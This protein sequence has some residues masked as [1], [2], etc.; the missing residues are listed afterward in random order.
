MKNT[1]WRIV[2]MA[3]IVSIGG[4][5]LGILANVSGAS[6]FYRSYFNLKTGSFLEGLGVSIAM[7]ATFMG[8]F[9]AGTLS[10]KI[11][12]KKSLLI[13]AFL[14]SFCTLGSGLATNYTFFLL[15]RFIGGFGI[16]ISLVV[17]PM[18]IAEF[19]PS[20]KRGFWVSFNQLNIGIGF[21]VAYVLNSIVISKVSDPD[22][23]WRWMLGIGVVFP[24]IYFFLMLFVPESPRW[25]MM[26]GQEERAKKILARL[27]GEQLLKSE[28]GQMEASSKPSSLQPKTSY[29]STWKELFSKKMRLVVIVAFSVAFFQMASGFN[30]IM[31]F[32]PKIFRLAGFSGNGSFFQSN[33]IG[34]T[35]VVMTIVSMFLID[36]LGRKPLLLIG[37]SLMAVSVLVS[38]IV[39]R[40]STFTIKKADF[41][42]VIGDINEVD[43]RFMNE[44]LV[45]F[46]DKKYTNEIEFFHLFRDAVQAKT[47]ELVDFKISNPLEFVAFNNHIQ[48]GLMQQQSNEKISKELA[49]T[50]YSNSK[51]RLLDASISI[52][53]LLVMI[54]IIGF[55][56][57]FSISL[58]P[59]TWA[60]LSEVFP[61][62]VRG[63]GISIAST[64]NGIAS[65]VIVTILPIELEYLGSSTTFL[66]YGLL[67]V[68]FILMVIKW[69]PETK[70]KSL[71]QI[72]K[73]LVR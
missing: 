4:L 64:L 21:L 27:G 36:R 52:N 45:S 44:V 7:L 63:L 48:E 37:V 14:F 29:K 32:A 55:I 43:A 54:A 61:G 47:L 73:E 68:V 6:E 28:M 70:G 17:V 59:I 30:S 60:L 67:M 50:I 2:V 11:G 66:I 71:E 46:S 10:D 42:R 23:V 34:I 24:V 35:M 33:L 31:F 26:N 16:G 56:I 19:S 25:L 51:D 39:F 1:Y 38:T 72:E 62:S 22:L 20:E 57:G 5:L 15:S 40:Q 53:S 9:I 13:A 12:R 65:F 41:E 8:T 18:F 69:F 49:L 58:G 3:F